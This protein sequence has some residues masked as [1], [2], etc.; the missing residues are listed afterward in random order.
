MDLGL[1]DKTAVVTASSRGL[2]RAI[3]EELAAEGARV[4]ISSRD[5]T[6]LEAVAADIRSRTGADVTPVAADLLDPQQV[7][8][9]VDETERRVGPIDILV[10]SSAGPPTKPFASLSDDDWR[11]ALDVKLLAQIRPCREVLPRMMARRGGRIVNI[12]GTHGLYP[13][14]YAVTAGVVNAALLNL[15]KALAEEGASANVLVNAVNPG[16]TRTDRITYLAE[17]RSKEEGITME[18]AERKMVGDSLLKR[19]ADPREVSA[20]VAFMVSERASFMTGAI[21]AVDGGMMPTI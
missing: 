8:R 16:I 12:V 19:M 11:E 7:E 1:S 5:S 18:E 13:H 6:A 3:A 15:T 2:G 14:A 21:V 9:L 17:V 10:N 4:V 20:L